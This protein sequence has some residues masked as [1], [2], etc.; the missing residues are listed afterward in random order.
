[1]S[2]KEVVQQRYFTK[3]DSDSKV[4]SESVKEIEESTYKYLAELVPSSR[5]LGILR[6]L[7]EYKIVP[8]GRI[9]SNCLKP[10]PYKH[11]VNCSAVHVKDTLESWCKT[12]TDIVL[13]SK[14]GIGFGIDCSDVRPG[15]SLLSS[16][17][18]RAGGVMAKFHYDNEAIRSVIQCNDRHGALLAS[19]R[20]DHPEIFEF[21]NSK[22][23]PVEIRKAKEKDIK[24]HA[25]YDHMNLSVYIDD[26]EFIKTQAFYNMVDH[27]VKYGDPGFIFNWNDPEYRFRN[28][29]TEAIFRIPL[30]SCVLGGVNWANIKNIDEFYSCV[31]NLTCLLIVIQLITDVPTE[32]FRKAKT[33]D[34]QVGVGIMGFHEWLTLRGYGWELNSELE[35]W[36]I[37]YQIATEDANDFMVSRGFSRMNKLRSL[38]PT[39]TTSLLAETSAGVDPIYAKAYR[40]SYYEHGEYK[41]TSTN[42]VVIQKLHDSGIDVSGIKTAHEIDIVA[43]LK[44]QSFLQKYVDQ[45]I[46]TTINLPASTEVEDIIDPIVEY[47]PKL[48]GLTLYR[49]GTHHG[50]VLVPQDFNTDVKKTSYID[51]CKL[52][53]GGGCG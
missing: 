24:A 37:T 4:S 35:D 6:Q 51:V 36:L 39:G 9:L 18:G 23:W 34:P 52:S 42:D 32:E 13:G 28:A 3:K 46:S 33:E 15:G 10:H 31:F 11:M 25:P 45:A 21:I 30:N 12:N 20:Y 22:N 50:Q 40:R 1:M 14:C 44:M 47:A 26:L 7:K 8:A 43:R 19:L 5:A 16:G 41:S 2:L 48:K 17:L 49:D 38:Q 27:A 53:D 29:C